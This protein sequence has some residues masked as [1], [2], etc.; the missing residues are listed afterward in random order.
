M[1][2]VLFVVVLLMAGVVGLGLYRGW[3]GFAS[4]TS[5]A[6]SNVTFTVDQDKFQEDR[7]AATESVQGLGGQAKDKAAGL[8]W[9]VTEGT[10][11]GV[12]GGELMIT[13]GAGK[14]HRHTLASDAKVTCDARPCEAAALKAGM[15]ARV[16]TADDT[17]RAAIRVE[18]LDKN[19]AFEKAG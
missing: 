11:V 16:T 7:K 4:D 5:D 19:A 1:R 17:P 6:K 8:G 10:V 13:D 14:E 12:E 15:R 2:T 3:F 9:R 18:A